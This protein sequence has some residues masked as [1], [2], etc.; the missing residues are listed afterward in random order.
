MSLQQRVPPQAWPR[1]PPPGC[2]RRPGRHL[3][4]DAPPVRRAAPAGRQAGGRDRWALLYSTLLPQQAT[5]VVP[6]LAQP[7]SAPND[8]SPCPPA[9][10]PPS[11]AH[12]L[13]SLPPLPP[14]R[15]A[16]RGAHGHPAGAPAL[17][18][19][20]RCI[21]VRGACHRGGCVC[22]VPVRCAA[23]LLSTKLSH[24]CSRRLVRAGRRPHFLSRRRRRPAHRRAACG[25]SGVAPAAGGGRPAGPGGR[26]ARAARRRAVALLLAARGGGPARR[27][28]GRSKLH[29]R[30]PG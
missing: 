29:N 28:S 17:H 7:R 8:A 23:P 12:T 4:G 26:A 25:R 18:P 5:G 11:T 30:I 14:H 2:R 19:C 27:Q 15:T 21:R 13:P 24:C 16:F 3:P 10:A 6:P 22:A 20:G 9:A 1:L